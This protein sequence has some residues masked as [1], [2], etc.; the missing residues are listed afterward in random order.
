MRTGSVSS[1]YSEFSKNVFKN[2]I[3]QRNG[4]NSYELPVPATYV[5]DTKGVIRFAHVGVDYMTG[6]AEPEAVVAALESIAY[7]VAQ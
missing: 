5:I 2:D 4:E 7:R 1:P 6:R 3:A